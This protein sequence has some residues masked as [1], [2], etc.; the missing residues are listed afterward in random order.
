MIDL[1]ES[2][3]D[4]VKCA[5]WGKVKI[6]KVCM[7]ATMHTCAICVHGMDETQGTATMTVPYMTLSCE[8]NVM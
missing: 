3:K 1:E 7:S 6:W 2:Q 4:V 8:C 5:T